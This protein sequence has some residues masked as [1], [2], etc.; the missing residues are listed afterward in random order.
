MSQ[1]PTIEMKCP[2]CGATRT[3]YFDHLTGRTF[4]VCPYGCDGKGSSSHLPMPDVLLLPWRIGRKL[5]RTLYAVI[6][7]EPA[8][9]DILLGLLDD[10]LVAKLIVD[11]HNEALA[12]KQAGNE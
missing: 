5:G 2:R 9:N 1:G 3:I 7:D 8:D 12:G 11:T 4:A 6:G 10:E